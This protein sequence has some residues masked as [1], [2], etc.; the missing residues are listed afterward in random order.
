[1]GGRGSGR[2]KTP[3]RSNFD[4]QKL[5]EEELMSKCFG[6]PLA[7]KMRKLFSETERQTILKKL[8]ELVFEGYFNE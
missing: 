6:K 7:N 1:M 3:P 2:K 5:T 8:T 4:P